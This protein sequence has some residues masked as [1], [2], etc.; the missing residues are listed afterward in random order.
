MMRPKPG[1]FVAP[2][3][4][5]VDGHGRVYVNDM[6]GIQVFDSN[7]QF[8]D[9]FTGSG[10]AMG[11]D[12]KNDLLIADRTRVVEYAIRKEGPRRASKTDCKP[13]PVR[14]DVRNS[15]RPLPVTRITA[16]V[17]NKR[18]VATRRVARI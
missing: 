18:Y 11:F 5:A 1:H 9:Q 7:G 14:N 13:Q 3:T 17:V 10:G 6:H 15:T 4:I 2:Q 8:I 16:F 12:D